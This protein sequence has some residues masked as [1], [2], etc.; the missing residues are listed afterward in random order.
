MASPARALRPEPTRALRHEP[1]RTTQ[2][3]TPALKVVSPPRIQRTR[4]PFLLICLGL[5]VGAML[6]ALILNTVMTSA[7]FDLQ[8]T[9][10]ELTR[11][12]QSNEE[13]ATEIGRLS[14]PSRV[15]QKA[16]SLGMVPGESII[17]LDLETGKFIGTDLNAAKDS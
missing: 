13:K 11:T 12:L 6:S 17:Y 5:L 8:T 14:A 15:S 3:T 2:R 7:A 10:H 16:E 1:P 4:V 9:Q